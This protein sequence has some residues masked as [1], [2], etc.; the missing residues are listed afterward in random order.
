MPSIDVTRVARNIGELNALNSLTYINRDLAVPQ[1][2]L[3]AGKRLNE[4]WE[5]PAGFNYAST[6]NVRRQDLK[7][8][9]NA[10]GDAKDLMS[11]MECGM[12]KIMDILV[13]MKNKVLEARSDTIGT[14]QRGAINDIIQD[15]VA[16]IDG[17]VANTQWNSVGLIGGSCSIP[18]LRFFTQPKGT[19][20][21]TSFST[22]AFDATTLGVDSLDVTGASGSASN[23]SSTLTAIDNAISTTKTTISDVGVLTARL[24]FKEKVLTLIH[25][26]AESSYNRIMNANMAEEQVEASKLLILQQTSTAMLA[27]ANIAPQFLRSLFG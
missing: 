15:Y 25:A 13:K 4:A 10:I 18:S 23:I 20:T 17:I 5:D 12:K 6:F 26:T 9:L 19:G 1:T 21:R 8:A 14:E 27:Q 11:T 16:E 24:T 7:I 2:Q 3:A 22:T